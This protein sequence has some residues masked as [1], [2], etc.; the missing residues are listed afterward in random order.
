MLHV[1]QL[2]SLTIWLMLS[3]VRFSSSTWRS[4]KALSTRFISVVEMP[5]VLRQVDDVDLVF[6][7][8]E[9]TPPVF[10]DTKDIDAVL[11]DVLAFLLPV[12][13]RDRHI[14]VADGR[15]ISIRCSKGTTGFLPLTALNSSVETPTISRSPSSLKR[16]RTFR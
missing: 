14:N 11:L 3:K 16:L 7:V 13:L 15:T 12:F 5:L 8:V 6:Q 4:S 9:L 2:S 1:A 10:T